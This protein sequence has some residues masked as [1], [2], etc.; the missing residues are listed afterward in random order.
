MSIGAYARRERKFKQLERDF[1]REGRTRAVHK[2][3]KGVLQAQ[4]A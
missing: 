3:R 1:K 4:E 2:K